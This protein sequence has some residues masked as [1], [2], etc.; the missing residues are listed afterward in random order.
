[1]EIVRFIMIVVGGYLIGSI[2]SGIIIGRASGVDVRQMGSGKTGAT[3][4]LR[5]AGPGAALLVAVSDALKGAVPVLLSQHVFG[6]PALLGNL[7]PWATVAAGL[8]AMAGHTYPVFADFRGGRGVATTGGMALALNLP[9]ALLT[10]VIF[11]IIPIVLTR[12]VSLG[13]I[14][15][16]ISLPFVSLALSLTDG[17]FSTTDLATFIGLLIAGGAIVVT[18]R[19]NIQ[20]ILAGTERKLGEKARPVASV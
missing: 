16:G 18:H 5:S 2:P 15:G 6:T 10:F 14:V 20:R 11:F 1:M 7:S 4:V 9:A 12:Y 13:S 3:N 19:D 17:Y 8:A